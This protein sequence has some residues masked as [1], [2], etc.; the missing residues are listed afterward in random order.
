[1]TTRTT[2]R[3][4]GEAGAL[5]TV[6]PGE[7]VSVTGGRAIRVAPWGARAL[8]HEVPAL[9]GQLFAKIVP[10]QSLAIAEPGWI[11]EHLP[12]AIVGATA[13][14][15]HLI[16]FSAGLAETDLDA[17]SAED[18]AALAEAVFRVNAGFFTRLHNLRTLG[19]AAITGIA[20]PPSSSA[21]DSG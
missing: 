16:R 5:G 11:A 10:L 9:L 15:W 19:R 17:L 18:L 14:V 21:P 4:D 2:T 6:F 20:S 7:A 8:I 13:E 1:M 12:K 3:P